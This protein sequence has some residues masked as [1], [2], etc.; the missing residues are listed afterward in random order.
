MKKL[1]CHPIVFFLLTSWCGIAQTV[2]ATIELVPPTA[3]QEA[4]SIWRTINDIVFFEAQGYTIHLPEDPLIDTLIEKSK[5]GTFGN[6]DYASIYA[7]VETKVFDLTHYEQAIQN[8]EGQ[9]PLINT[10]VDEIESTKSDWDWNFAMFAT[11]KIAFTLYGTGGSYDPDTGRIT[12]WTNKTGEFMNYQNPANTII[13]EIT[14]MGMEYAIVR[15]HDLP[16]GLKERVVDT[17][18]YLLFS[19]KLPEY[20]IQNMGDPRLDTYLKK[21]ADIGSLDTIVLNL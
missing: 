21:K 5:S 20:K 16:H 11:Y 19:E 14:H 4:T 2:P 15:K 17:F 8:V 9:L 6:D 13:H 3:A 10:L 12:L 1:K 18:V 7:L